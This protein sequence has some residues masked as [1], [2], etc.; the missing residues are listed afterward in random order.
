ML[1]NTKTK[2][3]TKMKTKPNTQ[4]KT[5]TTT[6]PSAR[7]AT[8]QH[9]AGVIDIGDWG[10]TE[11]REVVSLH[12]GKGEPGYQPRSIFDTG[13]THTLV[14][15]R[16]YFIGVVREVR[17]PVSGV[18]GKKGGL[19]ATG[20]GEVSIPVPGGARLCQDNAYLV[21]GLGTK[22]L[23]SISQM[24]DQGWSVLVT[25]EKGVNTMRVWRGTAE[26]SLPVKNGLYEYVELDAGGEPVGLVSALFEEDV[27][28]GA[29]SAQVP[30]GF[31]CTTTAN[32]KSNTYVG[33]MGVTE[34][35][36]RRCGHV[37]WGNQKWAGRLRKVFGKEAG[38]GHVK[39]ACEACMKAKM[40][41]SI[42]KDKPTRPATRPLERVHFD[43]SGK[44]PVTGV[45]GET[46]FLMIV[47]EFTEQFFPVLV[48]SKAEVGKALMSFKVAAERHFQQELGEI[49]LMS[50]LRSDRERVNDTYGI[51][52]W[53]VDNGIRHE[54]SAAYSQWQNGLCERAIQTVWQGAEAMRKDARAPGKWWPYSLLAFAYT[55]NLL[56]LGESDRSPY[57]K[58]WG[59]TV[60]LEKRL[61][62]LRI[63]GC[64][65]YSHVPE[66][67]R[68]KGD[69]KARVCV[70]LG[71]AP[72]TK[73]YIL[74]DINTGEVFTSTASVGFDETKRPFLEDNPPDSATLQDEQAMQ[75]WSGAWS[76]VGCGSGLPGEGG[77]G[78]S[79]GGDVVGDEVSAGQSFGVSEGSGARDWQAHSM[80]VLERRDLSAV[81]SM[82]TTATAIMD[83]QD[84]D[85]LR[86]LM[87]GG[88]DVFPAGA[89]DIMPM[90]PEA[91]VDL[92]LSSISGGGGLEDDNMDGAS[93]VGLVEHHNDRVREIQRQARERM[94]AGDRH[95]QT[96]LRTANQLRANLAEVP[97][98]PVGTAM[99]DQGIVPV[100][101]NG[102]VWVP[103]VSR[104]GGIRRGLER[105]LRGPALRQQDLERME[106]QI[107]LLEAQVRAHLTHP[108]PSP[109]GLDPPASYRQAMRDVSAPKWREAMQEELDNMEDFGVW[110]LEHPP[111]NANV[112]TCKWVYAFK[113]DAV[114]QLQRLKARLTC[115]GFTQRE[116][117]DFGATWA[118]TCRM[119]VFRMMMAEASADPSVQTA[120]WDCTAAFLHCPVDYDMYME[121]PPGY[122]VPDDD[123][124]VRKVCRLYKA[125]Y[126]CKQASRLFHQEV[127]KALLA[128]GAVQGKADECLY[129]FRDGDSWLKVLVHVD[130]FACTFNDKR[131]YD[132]VFAAM[133]IRFKITDYG[134]GP[135]TKFI[136]ICV[137]KTTEGFYRLHQGPYIDSVLERLGLDQVKHSASPERGGTAAK[138]RPQRGPMSP[139]DQ[140]FMK[141]VPYKEAVGALFY[142]ARSTRW[143]IC[144]ACSQVARFMEKPNPTHWAAVVRIYAYLART[145]GVALLMNSRGMECELVDQFLEG[146]SD[147][148]WAGCQETR[149]SHT[150]WMVRVGGSLVAWY[151]KRQTGI[152]QSATEAEYV[153]AAALANEVV[154]WRRLC[155]DFGYTVG[156]PVTVWCDNR[157]A[158][159]LADHDC[160]FDASKHIQLRYHVLRNYQQRG[161]VKV[162]WRKSSKMWADVLTK[163]CTAKHF[164]AIVSEVMGESVF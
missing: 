35:V 48:T 73:A 50:G 70:H 40:R 127:K 153:A 115:R 82:D 136:G 86:D 129:I 9:Q 96:T 91:H 3:K 13:A 134:G 74:M 124:V 128:Q 94:E 90:F 8:I 140:A 75:A 11:G 72:T 52:E 139:E 114:G 68:K 44:I 20:V 101:K 112:M 141:G 125:I 107:V 104:V 103:R 88:E 146:F 71:Y 31:V 41:R 110:K 100:G 84:F 55:R 58:W 42:S 62:R 34:L 46:G 156:G 151:S 163:N 155:V 24:V 164:Q 56:A 26:F 105:K 133:Q 160:D 131:L 78:G 17:V 148:D 53:C 109:L 119:R 27:D 145:K 137:E 36:H 116:G 57:E 80:P 154:W 60:P 69:D 39:A 64:K 66:Q 14:G 161:V 95:T 159:L 132:R 126:G 10:G 54:F 29:E 135:I 59:V 149:K 43:L 4:A 22:V 97:V 89:P 102:E 28:W 23:V 79:V 142:L 138:L 38:A 16:K 49:V 130:D 147:A 150:G 144:H 37:S 15:S 47:D 93:G 7:T 98:V 67:L 77:A 143:D 32:Y 123:G 63:W 61:R 12:V 99:D 65:A 19:E 158:T 30:I 157:G 122:Q 6:R 33:K 121:Q 5:R 21:Q 18:A 2:T 152:S 117:I 113:R 106:Q 51:R 92:D 85:R 111:P 81:G 108:T 87:S 83:T 1:T 162:Q 45:G 76:G 25:R 120:Q 118:P